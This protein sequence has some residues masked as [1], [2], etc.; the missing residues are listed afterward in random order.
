M[1]KRVFFVIAALFFA[2][3]ISAAVFSGTVL[4]ARGIPVPYATIYIREIATGAA[5]DTEGRFRI[6]LK[7]GKYNCEVSSLGY[8]KKKFSLEMSSKNINKTIV[9]EDEIYQLSDVYIKVGKED[10]SFFI[11][12]NAIARAPYHKQQVR[13]Y[14]SMV[15]TKGNVII[16]K[17][18]AI[19]KLQ[20]GKKKT[21]LVLNKT[22]VLE[23]HSAL[24]FDWPD[25]YNETIKAFSS[26]VP[27]EINPADISGVN[28]ASIY[29]RM[30]YGKLSPL[31]P[32]A[33][34]YYNFIYEGICKEENRIINKIRITPKRGDS[35]LVSGH[36]YIADDLWNVTCAHFLI[37][38]TGVNIELKVNFNEIAPQ[39]M[40]PTSYSMDLDI[41]V[42][43]VKATGY[44][45][46]SVSYLSVN[47]GETNI[48]LAQIATPDSIKSTREARLFAKK[49][50]KIIEEK[51][52]Q[53]EK[54]VKREKAYELKRDSSIKR[55]VDSMAIKRDSSYWT[56][57][58][59]VP[60]Q[61]QEINSYKEADSLKKEFDKVFD[62]EAARLVDRTTGNKILDKV[63]FDARYKVNKK[64]TLGYGGLSRVIGGFSF[65]DGYW[66]GQNL[67]GSYKFRENKT[68]IIEPSL[69]YSTYRR[70]MMWQVD[71]LFNYSPLKL[72]KAFLSVGDFSRDISNS[73][74]VSDFVSSYA[75]FLFAQNPKKYLSA[76]WLQAGNSIDIITGLNLE[77]MLSYSSVEPLENGN[78]K[79]LSR[80]QPQSNRPINI[81]EVEQ[82]AHKNLE[83]SVTLRFTPHYYYKIVKGRKVYVKST[84]PTFSLNLKGTLPNSDPAFSNWAMVS[85]SLA[86]RVKTGLYSNLIYNAQV[87]TFYNKKN[88]YLDNYNHF[89]ASDILLTEKSFTWDLMLANPYLYSTPNEWVRYNAEFRSGYIFLNYLPF[90]NSALYI[91]SLYLK[92]LWLPDK[93]II[94]S[95]LGYSFGIQGL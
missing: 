86:Q 77:V 50:V 24:D 88:I 46:S 32:E 54:P 6:S 49:S 7:P 73:S 43:G 66:L 15:Y 60:L 23:S 18:P 52:A 20:A 89:R 70:K 19:L 14:Q 83:Y 69:Y 10:R 3:H 84:W 36:I 41:S 17:L 93:K 79:T 34:N 16:T 65:T 27:A 63:M 80:K 75:S 29:D 72:G 30:F 1:K 58:R 92:G 71:A 90:L 21:N 95:E 64:L 74:P 78:I 61:P 40:M 45:S 31:A 38:E 33:F 8:K 51:R 39:I 37:R 67:Y 26:T 12:R 68:L 42:M 5:T 48:S 55:V 4:D 59:V 81:Y 62:E 53:K 47:K 13:N 56:D 87:G 94:H 35:K 85:F 91:E 11:M 25:Q 2:A 44:Y 57:I 76:R 82:Q 22:F 28:T 9:L